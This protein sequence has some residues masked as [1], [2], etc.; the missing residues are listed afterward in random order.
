MR[1]KFKNEEIYVHVKLIHFAVRSRTNT[2]IYGNYNEDIFK[3]KKKILVHY[4]YLDS[5]ML[6]ASQCVKQSKW[7]FEPEKDFSESSMWRPPP[8][9]SFAHELTPEIPLWSPVW[10]H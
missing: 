2:A 5:V 7:S 9:L 8:H 4:C 1:M 6:F 3:S 10:T